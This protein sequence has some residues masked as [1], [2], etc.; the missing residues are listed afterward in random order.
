M[1][2]RRNLLAALPVSLLAMTAQ[3]VFAQ[4]GPITIGELREVFEQRE[5]SFRRMAQEGMQGEGYYTGAIDGQWGPGT[6]CAFEALLASDR[7]RRHAPTWDFPR[8][9]QVVE[10]LLFFSS[11]AY[12]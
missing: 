10:T 8:N 5:I 11:D 6:Q 2:N 7:Y 9:I 4:Q 12:L 3:P 1:I